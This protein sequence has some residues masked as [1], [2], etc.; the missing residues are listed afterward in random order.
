M[1]PLDEEALTENSAHRQR[2]LGRE[3]LAGVCAADDVGDHCD[4]ACDRGLHVA[5]D[6]P[7]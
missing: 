4:V 6:G 5:D 7:P 3:A 2:S 1:R